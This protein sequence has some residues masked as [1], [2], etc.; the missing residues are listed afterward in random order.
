[1]FWKFFSSKQRVEEALDQSV[2]YDISPNNLTDAPDAAPVA[3]N[4][5]LDL[6]RDYAYV[7]PANT[8]ETRKPSE[9]LR[10]RRKA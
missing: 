6:W 3:V 4:A 7:M 2:G 8:E 10:A 1:M 5:K 9:E